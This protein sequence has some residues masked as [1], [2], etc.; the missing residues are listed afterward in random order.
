MSANLKVESDRF[1][2]VL[3]RYSIVTKKTLRET[4]NRA[5]LNVAFE[6]MRLTTR[7][8]A[9]EIRILG[10]AQDPQRKRW[11]QHV[12]N[13]IKKT[14]HI[15]KRNK[16]KTEK[17]N[18]KRVRV[19]TETIER[20][21]QGEFTREDLVKVSND[22]K[23]RRI[24]GVTYIASGFLPAV[25]HFWQRVKDKPFRR[26]G[27]QTPKQYGAPNGRAYEHGGQWNPAAV[28]E[29]RT[30]A[31]VKVGGP[32]LRSAM[33]IVG[34]DMAAYLQRKIKK[35]AEQNRGRK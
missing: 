17:Q 7:A 14:G 8:K 18:G 2:S 23:R 10:T 3:W 30:E 1:N 13:V 31:A 16:F 35:N 9:E 27:A 24:S 28:F 6:A 32:A 22:I 19:K 5:A 15:L 26:G 21:I 4:I 34:V 20:G 12:V 33:R 29:N 25:R 11:W